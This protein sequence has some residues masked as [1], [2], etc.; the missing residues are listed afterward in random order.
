MLIIC[1]E[2]VCS[3]ASGEGLTFSRPYG[4]DAS[5]TM[6]ITF[7]L[8]TFGVFMFILVNF[9]VPGL[10]EHQIPSML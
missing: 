3:K 4:I 6:S 8:F 1:S 9:S 10:I 7:S 2:T 5:G